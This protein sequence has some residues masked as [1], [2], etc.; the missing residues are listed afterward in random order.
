MFI[1]FVGFTLYPILDSVRYTFYDWNGIGDP[2]KF[3]GLKHYIHI[4]QDPFFWNAFKHTAIYTLILVP[5]QLTLALALAVILNSRWFKAKTIFR[6]VFFSPIVTSS[7]IVGIVITILSTTAGDSINKT[8]VSIGILERPIDW[9]GNPNTAMWMIVA[10]GVWI[11][12][13]YPLIYFLA[14][15]QS[16]EPD[17]YEAAKVD[18]AG[19]WALFW[20]IT[21][22]LIRPVALVI[23]LITTLHSLRVF[24]IVQVMTRGGPYFATDVVST[25][26]YRQAFFINET[27]DSDSRL[28]YASAAAFF[29]GL[30]I[31]GI[32]VLQL[33]SVRYAA[34]QRKGGNNT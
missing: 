2:K 1:L 31:M 23:L 29:M 33:L 5:T 19:S 7:A 10:V 25:Y 9:L 22:P 27:G 3:V 17:L 13:G 14:A 18:G 26:I 4:I 28:G 6:A 32:S 8:L 15:L 34:R 12:L 24:D 20:H 16:I 11:G 30:L 21:I